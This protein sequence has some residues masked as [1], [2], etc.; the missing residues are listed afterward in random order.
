MARLAALDPQIEGLKEIVRRL[1]DQTRDLRED[2]DQWRAGGASDPAADRSEAPVLMEAARRL[3]GGCRGFALSV[4]RADVSLH[5][6]IQNRIRAKKI[7][8]SSR[9]KAIQF[10]E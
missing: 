1:D 8:R 10:S 2:R 3:K 7:Q 6:S 4:L 9:S 5:S